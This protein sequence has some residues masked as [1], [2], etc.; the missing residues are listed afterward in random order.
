[1]VSDKYATFDDDGV[2]LHRLDA[3]VN[4]IPEG[5]LKVTE[6]LFERLIVEGDGVWRLIKGEVVKEPLPEVVPSQEHIN[7]EARA[8]LAETDWYVTRMHETGQPVPD[9][10]AAAR[11]AARDRVIE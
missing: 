4:K 6:Q 3:S 1:M 11:Q 8:Y 2:L 9:D 7:A 5:A 10:I